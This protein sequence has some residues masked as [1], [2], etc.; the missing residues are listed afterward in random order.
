M[1]ALHLG[2]LPRPI[3][4]RLVLARASLVAEAFP[5]AT[6]APSEHCS[7]MGSKCQNQTTTKRTNRPGNFT[8][9]LRTRS[10]HTRNSIRKS[11]I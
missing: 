5:G 7:C 9:V 1:R 2:H 11:L 4:P 8:P 6:E 10:V 3:D